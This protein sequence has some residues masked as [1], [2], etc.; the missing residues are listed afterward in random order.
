LSLTGLK[1]NRRLALPPEKMESTAV[2]LLHSL[3][4]NHPT[5][6]PFI[7]DLLEKIRKGSGRCLFIAGPQQSKTVHSV[8]HYLNAEFGEKCVA[9][10]AS[11]FSLSEVGLDPLRSVLNDFSQ[12]SPRALLVIGSNPVY[13]LP[14]ETKFAELVKKS[15]FSAYLGL[16]ENETASLCEWSLPMSDELEA[17]TDSMSFDGS[18]CLLQP[19]VEP[20]YDTRNIHELIHFVIN[21]K[22][23]SSYEIVQSQWQKKWGTGF[24]DKWRS[25]LQKGVIEN[26]R[27]PS[28]RPKS[29]KA[30][31]AGNPSPLLK[32][33]FQIVWKPSLNIYDGR[34]ANN[35]WLQEL[36]DPLTQIS[37]DN[38][39]LVG[40]ESLMGK[41]IKNGQMIEIKANGK[42]LQ[43][44]VWITSGVAEK[45]IVLS[46]GY[47]RTQ[48]GRAGNGV[49]F[50]AF[51]LQSVDRIDASPAEITVLDSFATL[52]CAQTHQN[53]E[54][55]EALKTTET[56]EKKKKSESS[57]Y[58]ASP[59]VTIH[60]EPAWAMVID[61]D[62]CTGCSACV[63]AC[64]SENNIPVVGKKGVL[65]GREMHWIRVDRYVGVG[66]QPVPCMH[67]EK[68]PCEPVCPV[69]ATVHGTDGL[70]QMIYNRCV[71]TRY[72]S[73]NCPY[74]VRRF[75]FL[76]F[77]DYTKLERLQKNPDVSIRPR[78]VM[79]KCTYCVQRI[80]QTRIQAKLEDRRIQD[81][82]VRTACQQTC[83]T[84]AIVFGDLN[85]PQSQV[86]KL[87]SNPRN[88]ALLEELGTKPR[89]TYLAQLSKKDLEGGSHA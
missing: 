49:G 55:S 17:W 31:T 82:E 3:Q 22:E 2:D 11:E 56:L 27:S 70:N 13:S 60:Q 23:T 72:C 58:P 41:K 67:C 7:S 86:R 37:W 38:V 54:Y 68:A 15:T 79:E 48:A 34:W 42:S 88:Y 46:I 77:A 18:Q 74:K 6:D 73:N 28:L 20:L 75:N 4:K 69:G 85:D 33:Q 66:F 12:K 50:N 64:Q 10:R 47:G 21:S 25:S 19:V 63:V 84:E 32:D 53:M 26:T 83:P 16:S 80:N 1:A 89:T 39:A 44:P 52:A 76:H 5:K 35:P 29:R 71:G 30:P 45:T 59:L 87:K 65:M 40:A 81:G 8:C 57:L 36:P 61:L 62:S 9:Y 43:A 51:T 14:S 78:G 24:P